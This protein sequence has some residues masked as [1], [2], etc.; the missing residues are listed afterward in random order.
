[1]SG[2]RPRLEERFFIGL[3][4]GRGLARTSGP[5]GFIKELPE[6]VYEEIVVVN[7]SREGYQ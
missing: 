4:D 6:D 1:V 2:K 7:D 5:A 3:S